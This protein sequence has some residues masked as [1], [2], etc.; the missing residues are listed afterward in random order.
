[1][2]VSSF[3]FNGWE[4]LARTLIVAISAYVCMLVTIR[5]SGPRT[6]A[7]L[8][9][10]DFIVTIALGSTLASV[11]ISSDVA[12]AQ[13]LLA[14]VL[15]TLMQFL[16]A[17]ATRRSK[18]CE[19]LVTGEP[20]LLVH[21][22]RTLAEAMRKNR[23]SPSAIDAAVRNAGYS[24]SDVLAIVLE[25]NGKLSVVPSRPGDRTDAIPSPV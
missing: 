18:W 20:Q 13:G 23:V 4:P 19:E 25:T 3:F 10:Y 7:Q 11:I 14:F 21:R 16:L 1:M 2:N 5:V 15:L 22:G 9:A 12:L 24:S 6:L 17:S 8:N